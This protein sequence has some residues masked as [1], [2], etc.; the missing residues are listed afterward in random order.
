MKLTP[1][2]SQVDN[3]MLEYEMFVYTG[4]KRILNTP[5]Y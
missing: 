1:H 4:T 2:N 5:V 3:L